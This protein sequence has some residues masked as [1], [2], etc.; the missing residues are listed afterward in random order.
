MDYLTCLQLSY[1]IY[2]SWINKLLL[3]D[4]IVATYIYSAILNCAIMIYRLA[5]IHSKD[6]E[7]VMFIKQT[8][9]VIG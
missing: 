9:L 1:A 7:L 8:D 2:S 3:V 5:L 6:T 4:Y